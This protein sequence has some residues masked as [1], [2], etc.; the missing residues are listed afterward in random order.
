MGIFTNLFID[1]DTTSHPMRSPQA[2]SKAALAPA[3]PPFRPF[4]RRPS[5]VHPR[6]FRASE[7]TLPRAPAVSCGGPGAQPP[8]HPVKK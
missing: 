3:R 1:V 8:P 7:A 2:L 6:P 4:P 5:R